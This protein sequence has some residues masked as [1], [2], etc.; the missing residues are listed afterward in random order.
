VSTALRPQA[1]VEEA[2]R[3]LP[4]QRA[5]LDLEILDHAPP[6]AMAPAPDRFGPR[7]YCGQE[8]DRI[9][10]E[11]PDFAV[12]AKYA[13]T[14]A[15]APHE[16]CTNAAKYGALSSESGRVRILWSLSAANGSQRMTIRWTET[17]GPPVRPPSR[18]GFGWRLVERGVRQDLGG[19]V[20]IDSAPG[21]VT[22]TIE[23]RSLRPGEG[24]VSL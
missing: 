5:D 1:F 15:M 6:E 21:G 23:A 24:D 20:Q 4:E 9:E 8:R 18:R 16:L 14:M 22:C 19:E 13:L 7:P 11:G 3:W 12:P 2:L 17:G 10:T